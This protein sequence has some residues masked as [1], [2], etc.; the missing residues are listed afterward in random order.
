MSS[1]RALQGQGPKLQTVFADAIPFGPEDV[2]AMMGE[3]CDENNKLWA[4]V[5]PEV[6]GSKEYLDNFFLRPADPKK[7]KP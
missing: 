5:G 1:T 4:H 7:Y 2:K 3:D 6:W